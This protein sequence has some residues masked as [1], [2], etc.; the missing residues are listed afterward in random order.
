MG[1]RRMPACQNRA[2]LRSIFD[3]ELDLSIAQLSDPDWMD[4][5][6]LLDHVIS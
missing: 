6:K 2:K 3:Q 5:A 4:A 1:A